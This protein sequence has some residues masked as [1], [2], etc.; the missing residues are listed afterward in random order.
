MR[1]FVEIWTPEKLSYTWKWENAFE[2]TPESQ[3]TLR[4]TE[5]GGATELELTHEPLPEIPVC[6]RH[7]AGW[8][9]AWNAWNEFFKGMRKEAMKLQIALMG[10]VTCIAVCTR[11][12]LP[13]SRSGG[14]R[15]APHRI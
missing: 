11:R 4:L 7:R 1:P 5:S 3:V 14:S 10:L 9:E 6:L 12:R 8:V 13:R 2:R 15:R